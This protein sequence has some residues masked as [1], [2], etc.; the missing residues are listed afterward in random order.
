[1]R[2]ERWGL[3]AP[4]AVLPSADFGICTVIADPGACAVHFGAHPL[5]GCSLA[6]GRNLVDCGSDLAK[7]NDA[8]FLQCKGRGVV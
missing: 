3:K 5:C 6:L 8:A 1:M 2:G 7:I 4:P